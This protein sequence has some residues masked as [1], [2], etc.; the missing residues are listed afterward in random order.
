MFHSGSP[1]W[2]IFN[3]ND[4]DQKFCWISLIKWNLNEVNFV[5]GIIKALKMV[6]ICHVTKLLNKWFISK[7]I[8]F[9][10]RFYYFRNISMNLIGSV[11]MEHFKSP[12]NKEY[13]INLESNMVAKNC[14]NMENQP[15]K[16]ITLFGRFSLNSCNFYN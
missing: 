3:H 16:L 9:S 2:V 8:I 6:F 10:N 1:D 14:H 12:K 15:V 5:F 11:Y 4:C 7:W 13:I